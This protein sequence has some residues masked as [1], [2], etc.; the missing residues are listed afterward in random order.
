M[1]IPINQDIETAY[2]NEFVK[3]F[4]LYEFGFAF[5]GIVA[6]AFVT[7]IA[8]WKFGISPAVGVYMGF[9]FAIPFFFCGFYKKPDGIERAFAGLGIR[10]G[11]VG[12]FPCGI[13]CFA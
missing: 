10:V 12:Q 3:G 11:D 4:S 2:R 1:N 7:F 8:W 5:G 6:I 9:P 13:F